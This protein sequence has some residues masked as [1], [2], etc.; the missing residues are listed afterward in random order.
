MGPLQYKV[1]QSTEYFLAHSSWSPA[2][3]V[4]ILAEE[5]GTIPDV[6]PRRT[7]Y[8]AAEPGKTT[9]QGFTLRVDYCPRMIAGLQ[10]KNARNNY[11][12]STDEFKVS[13]SLNEKGPWKTL[14]ESHLTDS[15]GGQAAPLLN[16][17][18][19]QPEELQYLKFELISYWPPR[20]GGL[21][22]FAAIPV[23]SEYKHNS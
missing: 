14:L 9:G 1:V 11:E 17:T 13:S 3:S 22:Y 6:S 4:Y 12:W 20:G 23:T 19:E 2:S 5:D 15:T 8:W 10:I 16:F 21:Q 18:F 7:N